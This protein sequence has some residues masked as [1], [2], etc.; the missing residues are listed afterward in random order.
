MGL[1]EKPTLEDAPSNLGI[2]GPYILTPE[3]FE[4]LEQIKPGALGEIQLTDGIALLMQIL[5][6]CHLL[7]IKIIFYK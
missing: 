4:S 5:P 1:V 3:V 2:T 6:S 7:Q